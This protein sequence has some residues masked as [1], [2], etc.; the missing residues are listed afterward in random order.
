MSDITP[1][2]IIFSF[3]FTWILGLLPAYLIRFKLS[4]KPLKKRFAIPIVFIVWVVHA[5]ISLAIKYASDSE[6]RLSSVL[7][8]VALVSYF[9]LTK[10]NNEKVEKQ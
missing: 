3:V 5:I 2:N 8:L 6:P 7:G 9:I 4:K 1:I 10:K